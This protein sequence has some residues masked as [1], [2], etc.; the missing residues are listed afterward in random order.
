[1]SNKGKI[2][3]CTYSVQ[4]WPGG[5]SIYL[6]IN[7]SMSNKGKIQSNTLQ[8]TKLYLQCVVPLEAAVRVVQHLLDGQAVLPAGAEVVHGGGDVA[9]HVVQG[10]VHLVPVHH[11]PPPY[12]G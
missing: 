11:P 1:M 7:H 8:C 4:C 5:L 10:S 6:A 9:Q 3:R 2:Q 12:C